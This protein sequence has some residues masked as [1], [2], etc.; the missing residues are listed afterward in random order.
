MIKISPKILIEGKEIQYLKGDYKLGGNLTAAVLTF[1][2]PIQYAG[3]MK[4]WNKE[5]TMF[6]NEFDT[7]PLFRGWI[8]RTNPTFNEIDIHAEDAFGYLLR[9]GEKSLAKV[10]L[11]D[12][13]N[14]DGLSA[15]AAITKLLIKA[16]LYSKLKTDFIGNTSPV[17]GSTDAPIRGIV[18]VMDVIK[19]FLG[20]ALD[21]SG[22]LP[23]PNIAKI[24]DDGSNSQLVIELESDITSDTALV[25]HVYTEKD[26]I[27]N[28]SIINRKVPTII[29]VTG[30]KGVRGTFTHD[31]AIDALDRNYFEVTNDTLSSP[32]ECKEF[33]AKIFQVNLALQYEYG[34]KSFE[35]MYLNEND[36]VSIITD[37]PEFSGKY[38]IIGKDISF[39]PASFSLTLSINKR[40]PVLAEYIASLD[41]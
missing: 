19:N 32:A 26:N 15:S 17:V 31:S 22:T 4:L 1:S 7:T 21:T 33:A 18:N 3:R 13:D 41:N 5:V 30:K 37:D 28:I 27:T 34:L 12:T 29:T 14:V 6:L 25:N 38:R 8:K 20:K 2:M 24:I 35:G 23:R 40:P 16:K 36:I 9:G 11:T 39:S 10:V